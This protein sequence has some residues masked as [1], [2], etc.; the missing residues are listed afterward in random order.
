M[1]KSSNQ[2]LK[3]LYLMK[4]LLEKTDEENAITLNQMIAEL[5]RYG[6]AAERKSIYDDIEAL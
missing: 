3:I 4:I 6:I 1:A 2:K 5:E